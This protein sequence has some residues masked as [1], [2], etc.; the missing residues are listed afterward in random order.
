MELQ[1]KFDFDATAGASGDAGYSSMTMDEE[2]AFSNGRKLRVNP[3]VVGL[4]VGV[5]V[6]CGIVVVAVGGGGG[7][8]DGG[9]GGGGTAHPA[10]AA[11]TSVA[12]TDCFAPPQTMY[13][14]E[15][16][17]V[18]PAGDDKCWDATYTF[19]RCCPT[20]NAPQS[21]DAANPAPPPGSCAAGAPVAHG[22]SCESGVAGAP[23]QVQC[24]DGYGAHAGESA[25]Y[26]CFEG[27]WSPALGPLVCAATPPAPPTPPEWA[28]QPMG[29]CPPRAPVLHSVECE[30]TALH[31]TC[32]VHCLPGYG[33]T[34]DAQGGLPMLLQGRD[35]AALCLHRGGGCVAMLL[36]PVAPPHAPA[37]AAII[38]AFFRSLLIPWRS[39]SRSVSVPGV[40][41]WWGG[42]LVFFF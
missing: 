7:G 28:D 1:Q 4:G 22:G 17:C 19:E 30:E 12:V 24:L 20:A 21:S 41:P 36:Q 34:V 33:A 32:T 18:P 35:A 2:L 26:V 9:G 38:A 42:F 15:R 16:C 5:L 37:A 10:V 39:A 13:T 31:E 25:L 40:G 6:V 11:P 3:S 23:C 29:N 8:G 14:T 27:A